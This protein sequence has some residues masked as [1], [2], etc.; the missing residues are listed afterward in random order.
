M[1]VMTMKAQGSAGGMARSLRDDARRVGMCQMS[2][3]VMGCCA[4]TV[5]LA[6]VTT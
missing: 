6:A 2:V 1:E 5:R 3:K 4:S